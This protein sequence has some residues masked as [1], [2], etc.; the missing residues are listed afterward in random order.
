[1]QRYIQLETA[2][3]GGDLTWDKVVEEAKCQ[4]RVGKEY[5]RFRRE[6]GGSSTP[7]CGDPALAADAISRGYK[8]PQQRSWKPS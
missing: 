4:E 7:S 6:N 8:K 2:R 3:E 5:A 1:M